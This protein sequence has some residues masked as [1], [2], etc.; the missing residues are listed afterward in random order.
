MKEFFYLDA[1]FTPLMICLFKVTDELTFAHA[2]KVM[3]FI[4]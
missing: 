4:K 3:T 1:D 2:K